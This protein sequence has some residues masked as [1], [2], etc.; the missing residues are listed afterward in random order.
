MNDLNILNKAIKA[1]DT[2]SHEHVAHYRD[3][4]YLWPVSVMSHGAPRSSTS[5]PFAPT[6]QTQRPSITTPS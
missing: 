4:G 6:P 2:V 1:I 5:T 3:E